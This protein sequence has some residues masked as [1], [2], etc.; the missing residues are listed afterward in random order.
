M[1][2]FILPV[3]AV[4]SPVVGSPTPGVACQPIYQVGADGLVRYRDQDGAIQV[5]PSGVIPITSGTGA[6]TATAGSPT[7]Y[8]NTT[9]GDVYYR[10]A[11]G[12]LVLVEM[13]V[14]LLER[15]QVG[16][17]SLSNSVF[18]VVPFATSITASASWTYNPTTYVFTCDSSGLFEV[19]IN[20]Q[21]NTTVLN[22]GTNTLNVTHAFEVQK[23]NTSIGPALQ[24]LD[25]YGITPSITASAT[26]NGGT[27]SKP[28][29]FSVGDTLRVRSF[30]SAQA[31][32]WQSGSAGFMSIC[33]R[34]IAK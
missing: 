1:A 9:T 31:P 25:V 17:L 22:N 3:K 2:D 24:N 6:P 32:Y 15:E 30:S 16:I 20:G 11:L 19:T 18:A 12:S 33:I 27:L 7:V 26:A 10:D 14:D 23:N 28:V 29:R 5:F 34:R 13:G 21:T 8:T 4:V